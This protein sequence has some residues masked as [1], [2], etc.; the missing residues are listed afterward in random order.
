MPTVVVGGQSRKVGKT[1]VA[2]GLIA[3]FPRCRWTAIKIS[4]HVHAGMD[5]AGTGVVYEETDRAGRSDTSRFLAAGAARALWLSFG[6]KDR[7]SAMRKL[8][9]IL[10]S[11]PFVMIESNRILR[12]FVPD[13]FILV[14]K[15]DVADFKDS[16][17]EILGRAQAIVAVNSGS[18]G[19]AR[20][21]IARATLRG[22]PVFE[23][24]DPQSIPQGLINF[25]QSRLKI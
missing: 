6:D 14:L 19:P 12:F 25:V 15:Y 20:K 9:P 24:P 13:L 11:D 23:T 22:V 18:A 16:A 5:R 3:A 4:S 21:A 8:S 1:S 2:A 10:K 17:K 7:E